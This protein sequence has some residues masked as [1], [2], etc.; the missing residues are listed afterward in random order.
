MNP[1]AAQLRRSRLTLVLLGVLFVG[2]LIGAWI[3][4]SAGLRPGV[5][6][7]YGMLVVPTTPLP[8]LNLRTAAG[9]SQ[10]EL[11]LGR[12]S[13]VQLG[14]ELCDSACSDRLT[15][16]RQV[17]LALGAAGVEKDRVQ[18]VFIVPTAA[19]AEVATNE[20]RE[21]HKI[22]HIVADLGVA[23]QRAADVFKPTDPLAVYLVDPNGNWLMTYQNQ[24]S[25]DQFQRGL[26][27]DLKK[28]LRLSSIG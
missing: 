23:G 27:K 19:A 1:Q 8:P 20:L 6:T 4:Y 10:P 7:N 25:A 2:P 14:G 16:S 3:L 18:L 15:S 9:D 13:L 5:T 21:A 22:L 26:L 17:R 11:L 12:W 28:L 24:P